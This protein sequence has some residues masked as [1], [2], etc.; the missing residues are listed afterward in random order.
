MIDRIPPNSMEAEQALLGC[1]LNDPK[2][3]LPMVRALADTGEELFYDTRHQMVYDSMCALEDDGKPVNVILLHERLRETRQLEGIGGIGY[4]TSLMDMAVSSS[5]TEYYLEIVADKASLR[6]LI[7]VATRAVVAAYDNEGKDAQN[8]IAEA[9]IEILKVRRQKSNQE[10]SMKEL[11]H[12]ALAEIE[13]LYHQQGAIVGLSTGLPDL[14][15]MTDGLH[16]GEMIVIAGYPGAGKS[17]LGMNIAEHQAVDCGNAVGVFSMEMDA[18]RL[19]MR[20]MASRARLNLRQVRDGFMVERDFPR[21]TAAAG[22][23]DKSKI[24]ICDICDMTAAKVRSHARRWAQQHGIKLIIVDYLQLLTSPGRRDQNREQEVATISRG[25]KMMATELNVPV[26]VLS[27]LNDD[28]KLRESRAIG[29]DADTIWK[30]RVNEQQDGENAGVVGVSLDI[31]KQRDGQA[32]ATVPLTFMKC[33][34]RF[35]SAAKVDHEG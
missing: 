19:V 14:D 27:Q 33:F 10:K 35:E 32:P 28:G 17:C 18:R 22:K 6:K 29:Q 34:T 9:E 25:M 2:E 12:A 7:Q 13:R 5:Q 26:I 21:L 1:I 24:H 3:A 4:I 11:V 16:N 15:K 31:S 30:L 23:L 20:L 8:I